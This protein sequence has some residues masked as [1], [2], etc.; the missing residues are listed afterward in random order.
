MGKL[1]YGFALLAAKLS[2][3]ALKVTKH[4]ATNFPGIVAL[5]ICPDFLKHI[6]KPDTIIGITG[7][8]GKTTI[9]NLMKDILEE[10]GIKVLNNGMG[11]NINSGIA[12]CLISGVTL[13]GRKKY[14]TAVL[15]IDERSA[16]VLFPYVEPDYMIVTNLSRD[17]IMRNAHPLYIRDFLTYYMP[18]KTKLILNADDIIASEVSPENE[19][20][21]FGI[22]KMPNDKTTCDNLINDMQIC[23]NCSTRLKYE[24]IRYSNIGRAYCPDCGFH[25]HDYDFSA[26][27]IDF[28]RMTMRCRGNGE[29]GE[30]RIL[31]ESIFNIYNQVSA[32]ALL[33][34]MGYKM[35]EIRDVMEKVNITKSRYG[36]EQIGDKQ[37][38]NMLCKE[39][40]AYATS[41]VFEYIETLPGDKEILLYNNCIGD[42][43][44][45]SENTCWLYDCDFEFLNDDK[46]K[47]IVVYGDRGKDYV[48][49][50]LIA[51]V[52]EDRI[53]FVKKPEEGVDKLKMVPGDHIYVLYGTDSYELGMKTTQQV[54]DRVRSYNK[55]NGIPNTEIINEGA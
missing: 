17:S 35:P 32:I 5:K 11:S 21:Y 13:F 50:L 26:S 12:S 28:D 36:L 55:E 25:S 27:D 3:A 4:N 2:V 51:G 33:Q 47:Q 34:V 16:R 45:W 43:H 42:T 40:N 44:H 1:R 20:Y 14:N 9:S 53:T 54:I 19:K 30:F 15:E 37:V 48:L 7:T 22:E 8:N 23:P 10:F 46:I 38:L 24:Y 18:K 39:K 41:R 6:S 52:P 49:R 29:E 31:N